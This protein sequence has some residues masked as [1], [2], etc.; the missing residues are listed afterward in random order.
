MRLTD[1]TNQIILVFIMIVA[2]FLRFYHF[3]ELP[4]M[5][6]ELSAWSRLDFSS[7]SELIQK[8]VKPDGHP[9][10]VQVFLY[11]WTHLFGDQEWIVKLPFNLMGLASVYL[12][13]KIGSIWFS[14]KTGLLAAAF[15]A[16][17]QFFV[18]YSP[19]ARPYSSG[20]FLTLMMVLYWSLYMFRTPKRTYLMGFIVFAALS[21]YN[22]H[23]SL[24]FAAIVGFSGLIL[25]PK[26]LLKEYII[27]GFAIFLLYLPHMSVFLHQLGVGG[28]GGEGLWLEKPDWTFI[29]DF[30]EWS[31][32]YSLINY[33]IAGVF[34]MSTLFYCIKY[35]YYQK[36]IKIVILIIW[37]FSPIIIG[38]WYSIYVNP[39]IQYSMLIFSFPYLLLML[40]IF[41]DKLSKYA[42]VIIII[43]V[44]SNNFYQLITERQHYKIITKQPFNVTA[45]LAKENPKSTFVLFNTIQDYQNYYFEKYD[46]PDIA[47][48]SIYNTN[49]SDKN[50]DLLLKNRKETTIVSCGLPPHFENIIK[51]HFP[52]FIK[53]ENVYTMECYVFSKTT[54]HSTSKFSEESHFTNFN[55]IEN[56]WSIDSNRIITDSIFTK[57]FEFTADQL[58]GFNLKDSLNNYPKNSII[59]FVAEFTARQQ[60][61]SPLWVFNAFIGKEQKFWRGKPVEL[62]AHKQKNHYQSFFSIDTRL[63]NADLPIDSLEWRLYLWNKNHDHF[64]IQSIS[65]HYRKANPIKYSLFEKIQ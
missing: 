29:I 10:G 41:A 56:N 25:I 27:S 55:S 22:H 38:L 19:I 63:I 6:D 62:L 4:Y 33:L 58:W 11:Y 30:F 45:Q 35:C 34:I 12:I 20:L 39:V 8:G 32:Q 15:S 40:A 28:I 49:I 61:I 1:K 7:F 60:N 54:T 21:S 3:F 46:I 24:L 51:R 13:Y 17:L 5:W 42:F 65:A 59:D 2:A 16:T 23:F 43:A 52:Y 37:S 64:K 50:L 48:L 36:R 14:E 57:Y 18:L 44:L 9:A 26:N 53:R 47:C 31:F